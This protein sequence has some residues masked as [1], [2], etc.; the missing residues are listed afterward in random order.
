VKFLAYIVFFC[1]AFCAFSQTKI[2]VKK[3]TVYNQYTVD[4]LAFYPP[5]KVN[6]A[7]HVYSDS[8]IKNISILPEEAMY[9]PP[10]Y[11]KSR[12]TW[13]VYIGFTVEADGTITNSKIIDNPVCPVWGVAVL[14]NIRA[15][16]IK[17]KPAIKNGVAVSS[18]V[19]YPFKLKFACTKPM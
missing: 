17:W 6:G 12:K 16:N 15:S 2:Q 3:S 19:E 4:S 1:C 5:D 14:R 11:T 8:M 7:D 13:H 10:Q 9:C 18:Y